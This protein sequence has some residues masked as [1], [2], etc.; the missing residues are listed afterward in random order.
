[1]LIS[2][3]MRN[4][5]DSV[6]ARGKS[7]LI[8]GPRQT[9][10]TTLIREIDAGLF[11]S[12]AKPQVR[13]RYEKDP[14]LLEREIDSL[15]GSRRKPPLIILDEIQ[16]IPGLLDS[17]QTLIDE[18]KARFLIT[19]SSARKLRRGGAVNLLP[20]RVVSLRMDPLTLDELPAGAELERLLLF[21]SLPGIATLKNR[22]DM[23]T[24]LKS[25]VETY[26]EEEI[27]QEALVRNVG[28]FA[29]FLELAGA[30]SGNLAHF[31]NISRDLGVAHTTVASYFEIL[32]DCLVSERVEPVHHSTSRRQLVRS[33]KV[34]LFDMGVRRLCAGEGTSLPANRWGRLFE[35][36]IGLELLRLSRA[37]GV[38]CKLGFWRDQS[39]VEVDWVLDFGDRLLPIEVKWSEAPSARDARHL[40]LFM[41]EYPR[42]KRGYV[43]CRTPRPFKIAPGVEALPW[44]ELGGV[45]G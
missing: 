45:L 27:R 18:K 13:L 1:M 44:R 22:R 10:K 36:F 8:L 25:Y 24:D 28:R 17:A 38:S 37:K 19:G 20:G 9:G 43:V 11:L 3:V 12:L 16:K 40:A 4:Q 26:L 15:K 21:G 2:R 32:E 31:S 6:L 42:A 33:S 29:R 39:G 34:L 14:G 30:E 7:A 35:Q 23:E 5:V 41:K